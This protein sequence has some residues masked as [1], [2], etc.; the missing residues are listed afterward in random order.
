MIATE[1]D[2]VEKLKTQAPASLLLLYD[3][4]GGRIYTLA[5]RMTGSRQDAE[6]IT[7]ETMLAVLRHIKAFR[8]KSHLYTWI[9][10][11]V[12]NQC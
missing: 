1:A 7:H 6:D 12:K 9:Y 3:A 8:G 5:F 10:A 11:I 2:L 4:Y